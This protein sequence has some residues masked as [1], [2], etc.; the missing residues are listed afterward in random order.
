MPAY[1]IFLRED[2][3]IGPAA[4]QTYS[5]MNRQNS[6]GFVEKYGL[7]PLA[8]YGATEAL[9]GEAPDGIVLLEFPTMQDAR[10]RYGSPEYQVALVHRKIGANY[11][12]LVVEGMSS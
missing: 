3:V 7:K 1:M 6:G 2:A 10:A 9:E 4:M 5:A 12:A 11:R 8:I